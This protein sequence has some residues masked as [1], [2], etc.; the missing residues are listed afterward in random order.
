M[1][2]VAE[3]RPVFRI[4]TEYALIGSQPKDTGRTLVQGMNIV[5]RLFQEFVDL[6]HPLDLPLPYPYPDQ[7][8]VRGNHPKLAGTA[9]LDRH[10]TAL[11]FR[12]SA[13]PVILKRVG[14]IEYTFDPAR[15]KYPVGVF[16]NGRYALGRVPLYLA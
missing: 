5:D 7:T 8:E 14:G 3:Y 1:V 16:G 12:E 2:V 6:L 13:A 10:D 15:P 4:K 9:T 11:E